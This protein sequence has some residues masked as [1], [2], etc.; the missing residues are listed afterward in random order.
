MVREGHNSMIR[1]IP[2]LVWLALLCLIRL[3]VH[4]VLCCSI[5]YHVLLTLLSL[6]AC[7]R[8]RPGKGST[9]RPSG[10]PGVGASTQIMFV[11]CYMFS[12]LLV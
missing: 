3:L 12:R 2:F 6:L 11:L 8:G 7:G 1:P 10:A 4:T 5:A 9:P